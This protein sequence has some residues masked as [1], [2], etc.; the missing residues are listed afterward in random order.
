MMRWCCSMFKTGPITRVM[1]RKYGNKQILTFY[2]IRKVEST[3][4]SKYSRISE[5]TENVKIQKQTVASPIF[6]WKDIDVWI[7][8]LGEDVDFNDA[9]RLG[10]DRVGCW[11][12]PNNTRAQ[13]LSRIYMKEQSLKWRTFLIEFAKRIGKPDAEEYV[14]SEKWKARQGGNGVKAAGDVKLKFTACTSEEH[15]RIYK[16][17]KPFDDSFLNMMV[18]FGIISKELGRKLIV[19]TNLIKALM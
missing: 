13:F 3:S 4:R 11:C 14:D 7:Y 2:G 19:E 1:N 18:P 5:N 9:Y 16:L 10:Y 8:I 15:A 12:C 6:F 17:V